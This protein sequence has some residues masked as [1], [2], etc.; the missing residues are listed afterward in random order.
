M[1]VLSIVLLGSFGLRPALAIADGVPP[2][3]RALDDEAG[4]ASEPFAS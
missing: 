3:G 2:A 4:S 1:A